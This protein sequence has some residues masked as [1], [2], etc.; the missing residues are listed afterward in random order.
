MSSIERFLF[1]E[2]IIESDRK[3]LCYILNKAGI[4]S[5]GNMILGS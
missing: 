2:E 4:K 3:I 1:E 5:N